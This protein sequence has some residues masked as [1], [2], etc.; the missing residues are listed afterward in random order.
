MDAIEAQ[1]LDRGNWGSSWEFGHGWKSLFHGFQFQCSSNGQA[2]GE[3]GVHL[4]LAARRG[5]RA[6]AAPP[7]LFPTFPFL[8]RD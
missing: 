6:K 8:P 7:T 5:A 3:G 2:A 1:S 4:R